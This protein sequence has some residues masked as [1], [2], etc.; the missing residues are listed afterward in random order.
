MLANTA[1]RQRRDQARLD[2]PV[3]DGTAPGGIA[4]GGTTLE[5]ARLG[6]APLDRARL[7]DLVHLA[8]ATGEWSALVRYTE[9]ERWY[10]RLERGESHEVWLLS[11][12]P[13]QRT[14][15]HDHCGS[16]GAFAVVQGELRE[17]T[18]AAGRAR[19]VSAA[20]AGGPGQVV[21]A[22]LR[23]RGRERIG[24]SRGEHPRVLPAAGRD[25]PVRTDPER[26]GPGRRGDRRG[27]L[28][29]RTAP[30]GARPISQ[31]LEQARSRLDRLEPAQAWAAMRDG[32]LLVDIR[33]QAQRAAEG[34]VPGALLIE[35]N[36][37][38]WRLD[39][40]SDARLPQAGSY[41]LRVDRDVL[42][43]LHLQPG[44]GRP[45]GP[46]PVRGDRPGRRIPGLGPGGAAGPGALTRSRGMPR[47]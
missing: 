30:P 23:A 26:P 40:A 41:D 24:R 34:E 25:A 36:V 33:P 11:W 13:G 44:R 42:G 16:S 31:V 19:P 35:R 38:E 45:A 27:A 20:F 46:R 5:A 1:V 28:V 47:P 12:L 10:H 21:R 15:F 9:D 39:P 43:G 22:A 6:G 18:P 4:P 29:I 8:A 14:G 7:A 37:L 2:R 17:W 3:L 32:A